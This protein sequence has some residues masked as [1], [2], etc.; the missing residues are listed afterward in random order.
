VELA[1][2]HSAPI[3]TPGFG[4]TPWHWPCCPSH[5]LVVCPSRWWFNLFFLPSI[6]ELYPSLLGSA[7]RHWVLPLVIG[8]CLPSLGST[9]HCWVLLFVVGFYPS[10]LGSTP[11][12][13]ALPLIVV[14]YP[15]SLGPTPHRRV[16]PSI[17]GFLMVASWP[18]LPKEENKNPKGFL[19]RGPGETCSDLVDNPLSLRRS[20][21]IMRH[22]LL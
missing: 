20:D 17:V 6:I 22:F 19:D 15:L 18:S 8:F 4:S 2:Q 1:A 7:F 11:H 21:G 5:R 3:N 10:S 14:L 12:C 9:P 16:L 13:C